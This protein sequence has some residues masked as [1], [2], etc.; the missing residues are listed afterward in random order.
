MK[1][2]KF[3]QLNRNAQ[4]D[5]QYETVFKA[6]ICYDMSDLLHKHLKTVREVSLL[7][8]TSGPNITWCL[9]LSLAALPVIIV[10]NY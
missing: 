5:D 4:L 2:M 7:H 9:L 8:M 10:I 1:I 3:L 6:E